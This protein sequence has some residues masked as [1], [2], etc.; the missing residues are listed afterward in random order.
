MIRTSNVSI[1]FGALQNSILK[2]VGNFKKEKRNPASFLN[3]LLLSKIPHTPHPI[4]NTMNKSKRQR[5]TDRQKLNKQ[6]AKQQPTQPPTLLHTPQPTP[7]STLP[8][9]TLQVKPPPNIPL[10]PLIKWSH[11]LT[12]LFPKQPLSTS[13]SKH[14]EEGTDTDSDE[15]LRSRKIIVR[16]RVDY[17]SD[18]DNTTNVRRRV[19]YDTDQDSHDQGTTSTEDNSSGKVFFFA[20]VFVFS[21][22]FLQ[23]GFLSFIGCRL[24]SFFCIQET[25]L[26]QFQPR[27]G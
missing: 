27:S 10:F 8:Q 18:Q 5:R 13:S 1:E 24:S 11:D 23:F 25:C 14:Q 26:F 15:D 6:K 2:W 20:L 21:F 12:H 16:R 17:D 22:C 19:D 9:P 3:L 4:T 7:Q